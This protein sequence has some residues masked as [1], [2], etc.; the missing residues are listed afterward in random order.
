MKKIERICVEKP[1][2]LGLDA[3]T[4]K[5]SSFYSPTMRKARYKIYV[6]SKPE[7]LTLSDGRDTLRRQ[8][9]YRGGLWGHGMRGVGA[10][11]R[12]MDYGRYQHLRFHMAAALQTSC[13]Y[14]LPKS[15]CY[16]TVSN[17][18]A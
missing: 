18:E 8:L 17:D 7:T 4:P 9:S 2:K 12:R 11:K 10:M 15:V 1:D 13:H 16:P 6:F 5:K 3:P 14:L